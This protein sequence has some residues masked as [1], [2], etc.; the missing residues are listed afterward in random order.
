ME[1][2]DV[3]GHAPPKTLSNPLAPTV[4]DEI[5]EIKEST[6]DDVQ[7]EEEWEDEEATEEAPAHH[8]AP[9]G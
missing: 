8:L 9:N 2:I 3:I 6:V 1:G 4:F 7:A 5:D